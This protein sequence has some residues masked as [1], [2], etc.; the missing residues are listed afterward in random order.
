[1]STPRGF[2]YISKFQN[3]K[4]VYALVVET[5]QRSDEID[6]LLKRSQILEKEQG[7]NPWLARILITELLW[8]KKHLA[9]ES[10]PVKTLLAYK[11]ILSAH[12]AEITKKSN[13]PD[14]PKCK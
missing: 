9:G 4:A 1:M 14:E 3:V 7:L 8:R 6:N 12:L 2:I 10:K 5:L 13:E 11:Q